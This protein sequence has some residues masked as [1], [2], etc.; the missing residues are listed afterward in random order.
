MLGAAYMLWLYQRTM[1]GKL[2]NP[3]NENLKDLNLREWVYLTPLVI[4]CFWIGL[5][6]KPFFAMLEPAT[7]RLTMVLEQ[8]RPAEFAWDGEVTAMEAMNLDEAGQVAETPEAA[9]AAVTA[10]KPEM[11]SAGGRP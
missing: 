2:D 11:L 7:A 10:S 9:P 6:P 8:H 4:L 3:D 1:F 5:Y